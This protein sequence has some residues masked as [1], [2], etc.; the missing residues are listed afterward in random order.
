MKMVGALREVAGRVEMSRLDFRG[1]ERPVR[2]TF[3]QHYCQDSRP[4]RSSPT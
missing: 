1:K 2:K 3:R 4:A